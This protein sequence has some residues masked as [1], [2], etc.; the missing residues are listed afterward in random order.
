MLGFSGRR[1]RRPWAARCRCWRR[2]WSRCRIWATT[3][4]QRRRAA[5]LLIRGPVVFQGYYRDEAATREARPQPSGR[6]CD[7][8]LVCGLKGI[9]SGLGLGTWA[10]RHAAS[11][12]LVGPAS[13]WNKPCVGVKEYHRNKATMREAPSG[14]PARKTSVR[15]NYWVE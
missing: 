11:C 9:G 5:E 7:F 13:S 3:R 4:W 12:M 1:T 8:Y 10:C 6:A 14:L 15:M 2:G